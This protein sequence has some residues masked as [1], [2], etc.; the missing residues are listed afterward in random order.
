MKGEKPA[1]SDSPEQI[2]CLS[3][4]SPKINVA[5]AAIARTVSV[6]G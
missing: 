6:N 3:L 1:P 2:A 5:S 4:P